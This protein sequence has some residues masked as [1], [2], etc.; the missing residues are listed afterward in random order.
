M[1]WFSFYRPK[2]CFRGAFNNFA[3]WWTN[4]DFCHCELVIEG[5]SEFILEHVQQIYVKHM[6]NN[7]KRS[8]AIVQEL[9]RSVMNKHGRRLIHKHGHGWVSFSLLF[10]DQ[11]RIRV[12]DVESSEP[13]HQTP[14][15]TNDVVVWK[16][17]EL[18]AD[19]TT[20]VYTWALEEVGKPYDNT[21]ALFSW[22]PSLFHDKANVPKH[23]CS[24][25]CVR[26]LQRAGQLHAL[27]A[28][29]TTPNKLYNALQNFVPSYTPETKEPDVGLDVDTMVA[30]EVALD[31][32]E[33]MMV[34]SSDE[35]D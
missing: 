29:H 2:D 20:H 6:K 16:P 27:E 10:G 4:G 18:C 14:R 34:D 19:A 12:L 8:K 33:A 17:V 28:S 13:W 25:F 15:Q 5:P 30:R 32:L 26:A 22:M 24:E 7:D 9:E 21:G 35:E 31:S 3:A 1:L 23:F 11:L